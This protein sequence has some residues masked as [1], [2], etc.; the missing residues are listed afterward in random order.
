MRQSGTRPWPFKRDELLL[1]AYVDTCDASEFLPNQAS[2]PGE[3][4]PGQSTANQPGITR[5]STME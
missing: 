1:V 2:Q 4:L 3:L 5:G